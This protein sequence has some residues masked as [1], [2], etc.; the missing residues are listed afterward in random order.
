MKIIQRL[1][2]TV[3]LGC[4]FNANAGGAGTENITLIH[5]GDTHGQIEPAV[6]VRSDNTN[7]DLEGGLARMFTLV[8]KIRSIADAQGRTHLTFMVGDT[9]HGGVEVTF[10]RGDGIVGILNEFDI[11]LFA[12]G[13]WE[14]TY[15]TCRANELWG[16]TETARGILDAN[17]RIKD[18][19]DGT[20]P[21][22]HQ[23]DK[24]LKK[25]A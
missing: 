1:V 18:T 22:N 4:T 8:K 16:F 3:A 6:N 5:I 10:T 2:A 20:I 17:S 23:L 9:S 19:S 24:I 7:K 12:P 15:G 25:P 13:N 11:D 14:F 21:P